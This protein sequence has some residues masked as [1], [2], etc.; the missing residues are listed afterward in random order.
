M[1][2]WDALTGTRICYQTAT[3]AAKTGRLAGRNLVMGNVI[4]YHGT[5]KPFVMEVF[6]YEVGTVGF[7]EESAR[8][9][10]FDVVSSMT[11]S[12][13]RRRAFGGKRIQIKLVADRTSQTLVGAQLVSEELVAGKID[14]LA[15]AIAEKVPLQRLALID[16]CYSPTVGAGYEAV[17]MALDNLL[18][19]VTSD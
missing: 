3:N 16:T 15:L 12:S 6:G 14:R 7:T 8:K 4:A 2:N 11:T 13:T 1:E 17:T 18:E 9:Q 10:G 5:V 19:E